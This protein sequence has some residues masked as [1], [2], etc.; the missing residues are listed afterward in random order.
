MKL[1]E[2][3]D[4]EWLD[5]S[6]GDSLEFLSVNGI[7]YN[8][9]RPYLRNVAKAAE[10]RL[11]EEIITDLKIWDETPPV[12]EMST[13]GR[14]AANRGHLWSFIELLEKRYLGGK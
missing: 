14:I 13:A 4:V 11:A 6:A 8:D 1:S 12:D 10:D 7:L 5:I 9:L 3:P 2:T